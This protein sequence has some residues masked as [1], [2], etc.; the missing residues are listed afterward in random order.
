MTTWIIHGRSDFKDAVVAQIEA[1]TM[2]GAFRIFERDI[3]DL[4]D[5]RKLTIMEVT[6]K[7]GGKKK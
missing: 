1:K 5:Y 6:D 3:Y 7:A 2:L 4:A